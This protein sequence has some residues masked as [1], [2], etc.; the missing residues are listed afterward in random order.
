MKTVD[1]IGGVISLFR[2][3]F[4]RH[5]KK[6]ILMTILGF[7]GGFFG[8]IG[9]GVIIPL[10]Y[11]ITNQSGA[12]TDS[13]SKIISKAFAYVHLTPSL[14]T[15]ITLMIF[16]FAAKAVFLYIA[17]YLSSRIHVDYEL[18]TRERLFK[19]TLETDWPYLMN[20]K[21]GYLDSVLMNDVG[22]ISGAL[23]SLSASIL[24]GTSLITYAIIAINISVPITLTTL[25][26]GLV[27]F[28]SLKP[29]FYKVRKLTKK[30]SDTI[31]EVSHH[32]NQHIIGGKTIKSMS[33]EKNVLEQGV[34]Y[35]E[36]L[37]DIRMKQY[38]YS[39]LFNTF[40]E[41]ISLLFIIIIF[42][43]SYRNPAFNIVTFVAI[44]YLVQK[45]FTF[46]QSIQG[47]F[48][49]INESLPLIN[50]LVNYERE[51]D[52]NQE[53]KGGNKKFKFD[54]T[55]KFQNVT[56]E[57]YNGQKIINSLNLSIDKGEIVGVVGPSGAG[58]T[59]IIDLALRL[60]R[61]GQGEIM[62]DGLNVDEIDQ[63]SWRNSIGYVSQDIF[64]LNDT[65]ENN[66]RFYNNSLNHKDIVEASKSANIYDFTETLPDKFQTLVGERGVHLSGGQRQRI[67][68]AR[69]LARK[70][71]ILVLDEATSA[72]DN[73]SEYKI[74]EAIKNLRGKLTILI[75]A[76]RLSTVMNSDKI[77]VLKDG[78][79]AEEGS[80][81]ELLSNEQSYF[82]KNY[83]IDKN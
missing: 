29:I 70:P 59:T 14:P 1:K 69:I 56:F 74:Q 48:N 82:Y 52:K 8:G 22:G 79:I 50:V 11:I 30:T 66:I 33:L 9:I 12:G 17:N 24:I 41:P 6:L 21:I 54:K 49:T 40:L 53:F 58:K 32:I 5:T 44:I 36:D 23:N 62:I 31:K 27:L 81:Q 51:L 43:T 64:L 55:L 20:Q 7:V 80:P 72:L 35:F 75:V 60:L 63:K 34:H 78:I 68:L 76:H 77:L 16:L 38:K 46:V 47:K 28:I 37:K 18:E 73:E 4:K 19:K 26:L 65:I 83:N 39:L 10:F 42:L 13:I 71:Q 2:K 25:G 67:V 57:Y 15:I 61:P 45:M 3:A